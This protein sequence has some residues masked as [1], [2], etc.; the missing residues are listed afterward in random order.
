L[1]A[2]VF[3]SSG[4]QLMDEGLAYDRCLVGVVT[5]VPEPLGLEVHDIRTPEQMRNVLRN[6]VDVVLPEGIAVLNACDE[7]AVSFEELSDGDVCFYSHEDNHP[8]IAAAREK[9]QRVVFLR[10]SQIFFAHGDKET[11]MLSTDSEPIQTLIQ[12]DGIS[13]STLCAAV[14][15][16][17]Y[18]DI[19]ADLIRA[20]LKSFSQKSAAA[21]T[22]TKGAS[23]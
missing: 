18:L 17:S 3:E 22:S 19:S 21:S 20:G 1:D 16:A 7:V 9:S 15:V 13:L 14:A 8:V 23:Q 2:A 10:G 6:Q 5:G 4:M 12:Q 11:S